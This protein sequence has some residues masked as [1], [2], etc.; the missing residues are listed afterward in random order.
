MGA[1]TATVVLEYHSPDGPTATH[2][3]STL[4]ATSLETLRELHLYNSFI[5]L[6]P[7]QHHDAIVYT[8]APTWLPID[9]GIA[10][11]D[12]WDKLGLNDKELQLAGRAAGERIMGSY[13][14]TL[15]RTARAN[16]ANPWIPL[17]QYDRLWARIVR[18]G[19]VRVTE[20]GPKDALIETRGLPMLRGQYFRMA[21][22]NLLSTAGSVF[23]RKLYMRDV[24]V[25]EPDACALWASWV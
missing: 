23:A 5:R 1:V 2:I 21:Y 17:R 9:T 11:Y 13:L 10:Y 25:E 4:I 6:L 24:P 22:R 7:A 18:G 12:T 15:A 16:G 20:K 14:A 8:L 3:R 19:S